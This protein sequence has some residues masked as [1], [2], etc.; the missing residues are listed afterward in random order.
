MRPDDGR[1]IPNFFIQALQGEPLTVY[2]DGRQ[3]R[4]F[5]FVEDLARGLIALM[6]S[7]EE[8]PVNLG[9]PNERTVLE[10][11]IAINALVGN[12]AGIRHLDLPEDDPQQRRP[13]ISRATA[14]CSWAPTV[15][16][17]QGLERT[18]RYFRDSAGRAGRVATP[19]TY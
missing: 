5:C 9:N 3:T 6:R 16:L 11:A 2:G 12:S 19:T 17:D 14:S 18:F 15:E 13:D 1:I 4:S 8:R 10:I 7:A